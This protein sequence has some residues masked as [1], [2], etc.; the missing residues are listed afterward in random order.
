MPWAETSD[1]LIT[2]G[3]HE[4]LDDAAAM[5]TSAMVK[6]LVRLCR[7]DPYDAYTLCSLAMDLRISQCVDGNKGVH[8]MFPKT[9]LPPG[10]HLTDRR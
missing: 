9:A 2:I 10:V 5:A 8:A 4:D 7:L 1:A 6:T 3:L